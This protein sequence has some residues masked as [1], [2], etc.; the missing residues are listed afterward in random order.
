MDTF[1]QVHEPTG[2]FEPLK[3][4]QQDRRYG[5]GCDLPM[6]SDVDLIKCGGMQRWLLLIL[7]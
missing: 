3:C 1:R 6:A 5:L 4:E 7:S 2:G